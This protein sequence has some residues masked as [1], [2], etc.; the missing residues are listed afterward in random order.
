MA[1]QKSLNSAPASRLHSDHDSELLNKISADGFTH[2]APTL[3]PLT[4]DPSAQPTTPSDRL[5]PFLARG[6]SS[7]N[8]SS[9]SGASE[10]DFDAVRIDPST[11][12]AGSSGGGLHALATLEK[13][14]RRSRGG[15]DAL[16]A[17]D[18]RSPPLSGA[19]SERRGSISVKLERTGTKGRYLLRADDPE[20]REILRRGVERQLREQEG[21]KEIWRTRFSDLVFTRRFTAFDRRDPEAAG[22]VFHGF[23]TLFW[24]GVFLM[25]VKVGASNYRL[26]GSVLGSNEILTMMFRRDVLLLGITDG[27]LCAIPVVCL[28]FQKAILKGWVSWNGTGWIIQNVG[29]S[30]S[31]YSKLGF[32][33]FHTYIVESWEFPLPHY[34]RLAS[35][36]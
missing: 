7:G 30:P 6:N 28:G 9:A 5:R 36:S 16:G 21:R 27:I 1:A 20:V 31:L 2:P 32:G 11:V 26:Y 10:Y 12:V 34:L 25:L 22:S 33:C 35:F 24:L 17:G 19:G 15:L 4:D 18:Q 3:P 29:C 13:P 14:T 23:F 8:I